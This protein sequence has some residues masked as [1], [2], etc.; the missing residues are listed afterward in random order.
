MAARPI[1]RVVRSKWVVSL[2]IAGCIIVVAIVVSVIPQ[3]SDSAIVPADVHNC[4]VASDADNTPAPD[5]D[6]TEWPGWKPVLTD[7]FDRCVLGPDWSAYAGKPGGNPSSQWSTSMVTV[8]NGM[9]H[10]GARQENGHWLTGGVANVT[11]PQTYGR[12][13]VRFRIPASDE[14]SFHLLLWPQ[15]NSWPPE[16]DVLESTDGTRRTSSAALHYRNRDGT[17]GRIMHDVTGDFTQWNVAAVEWGPGA[18]RLSLNGKPWQ[19]IRD[20]R[21]PAVPMWLAM[22]IESAACQRNAQWGLPPCP[23][24]GTPPELAMDVDWVSVYKPSWT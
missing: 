10:L 4:N 7:N 5:K 2:G 9:L 17:Q 21:V 13:A 24:A 12:W 14:I 11:R 8:S 18:I 3:R 6:I 19:M 22:Q 16:I 20:A 1:G 15:D 23:R